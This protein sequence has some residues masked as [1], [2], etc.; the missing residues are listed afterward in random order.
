MYSLL[1]KKQKKFKKI[2]HLTELSTLI[3]QVHLKTSTSENT[4]TFNTLSYKTYPK[5]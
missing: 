3:K 5:I 2:S 1:K 4:D